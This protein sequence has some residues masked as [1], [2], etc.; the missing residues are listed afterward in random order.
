[1]GEEAEIKEF[2]EMLGRVDDIN[3]LISRSDIIVVPSLL[4]A[5]PYVILE[6]MAAGRP[7]ATEVVADGVEFYVAAASRT[8]EEQAKASGAWQVLMDAGAIALP[9]SCGPLS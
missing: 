9:P 2:L 4:E 7:V 6:A 1:M 3:G 5:T 8:V